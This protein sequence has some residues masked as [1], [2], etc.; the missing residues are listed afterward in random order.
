LLRE[1]YAKVFFEDSDACASDNSEHQTRSKGGH[2]PVSFHLIGIRFGACK[3]LKLP[4]LMP[5]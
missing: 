4:E 2:Q 1:D 5:E 3:C